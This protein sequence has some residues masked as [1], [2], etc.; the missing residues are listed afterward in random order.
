[1]SS[2]DRWDL[3]G[4]ATHGVLQTEPGEISKSF[5]MYELKRRGM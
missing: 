4:S 5:E 2:T 3:R 1:M